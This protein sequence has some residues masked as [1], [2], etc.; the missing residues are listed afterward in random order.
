MKILVYDVAAEDGGGLFVLKNF[1]REVLEQTPD[2]IEWVFVVSQDILKATERVRVLTYDK[3]K[4]SWM[5]RLVFENIDFPGV[6]KAEKPDL[7]ISLQ[8]MPV[9]RYNGRQFV[10]LHQSLQYCPKK[11]SFLKKEER[12]IAIRQRVICNIYRNALPKSEHIFV[13]TNWIKEAT[14]KW[15]NWSDE[16][17]TV[18]PVEFQPETA[19]QVKVY[20]GRDSKTFFY[21][22]RA[23]MYKNHKVVIEACKK[24]KDE[25]ME[26]YKVIF[27]ISANDGA[28]AAKLIH[29]SEGLPIDYIGAVPY[30]QMWDYYSK[31]ILLFPS[32]LETCGL[33]MLEAQASQAWI[34]ASDMP[35]S[36]EALEGYPNKE[37]FTYDSA[38]D[39]AK[40]MKE[41]IKGKEYQEIEKKEKRKSLSLVESMLKRV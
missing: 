12:G 36:H 39:L 32:Y 9:K 30:E 37:Y 29:D 6:I 19:P 20:N 17:I 8:N 25:R 27:T 40:R 2:N 38:D 41:F 16:K 5:H 31:T 13:Q 33:P 34:L 35:F 24:L 26:D 7:V 28:Y 10:Y 14:K 21:P 4:K 23:E 1:Y 11:F 15:L 18:V 3:P 22:A